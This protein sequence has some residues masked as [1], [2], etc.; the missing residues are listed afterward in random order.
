VPLRNK[1]FNHPCSTMIRISVHTLQ[2]SIEALAKERQVVGCRLEGNDY[3]AD[4]RDVLYLKGGQI[5]KALGQL[6]TLYERQRRGQED[7]F[8][9]SQRILANYD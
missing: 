3:T 9:E 4:E 2:L 5:N 1:P 7:V 8:P 6:A